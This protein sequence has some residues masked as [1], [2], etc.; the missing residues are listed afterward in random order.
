MKNILCSI[1]KMI[2]MFHFENDLEGKEISFITLPTAISY[3]VK[4][5]FVNVV[6]ESAFQK[7]VKLPISW[8]Q[9]KGWHK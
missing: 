9:L 1:L 7:P 5:Y 8:I 2:C 6:D 4:L 3:V